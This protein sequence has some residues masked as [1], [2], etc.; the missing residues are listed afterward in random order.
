MIDLKRNSHKQPVKAT[1]RRSRKTSIY[2]PY[3]KEDFRISRSKFSD[4]LTCQRCFYLDRVLGLDAPGTPGWTLNETTDILLKNEFDDCREKQIPHRLFESNGIENIVPYKHKDIDK[5]RDSLHHGL[6]LRYKE[7]NIILN[8][9]IDDIWQDTITKKLIIVDYKSQAKYGTVCSKEYLDDPYHK[10]Y[11][12]QMDFYAYLL[13][14][15]GFDVD[16]TSYFL[17]CNANRNKEKFNKVMMFDEYLVSYCW[18]SSWIENKIDEMI[19][20]INQKQIPEPNESCKNCAYSNEY[21]KEVN[22]NI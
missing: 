4:F 12:I 2:S 3:Q 1:G 21:S 18:N 7:T 14:G 10:G 22:R 20:L 15:M 5:W 19:T 11:K 9:G 17:V 16:S 6:K 8:G 13:N